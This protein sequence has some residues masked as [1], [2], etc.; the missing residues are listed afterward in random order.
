MIRSVELKTESLEFDGWVRPVDWLKVYGNASYS[1]THRLANGEAMQRAPDFTYT[2]GAAVDFDLGSDF[3][4]N[5]D[6]NVEHSDTCL[7][8]PVTAAGNNFSGAYT[9]L[10]AR[11]GLTY[12]PAD[13]SIALIGKNL[14]NEKY[15]TFT[16]GG[17]FGGTVGQFN[18]PATYMLEVRKKF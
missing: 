9:L 12:K 8:Q 4:L 5:G 10:N 14:T 17:L 6:A 7:H 11:I 2:L 3:E 15:T 16:F 1:P 18:Q 13:I